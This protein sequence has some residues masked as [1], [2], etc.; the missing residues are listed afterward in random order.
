[1]A[2]YEPTNAR[3]PTTTDFAF[4]ISPKPRP[5]IM[6]D[7]SVFGCTFCGRN[8]FRSALA[9][10][11]HQEWT[12]CRY[13]KDQRQDI[14]DFSVSSKS[15]GNV[16]ADNN[17]F[18]PMDSP[19]S[20]P[21]RL[22][23]NFQDVQEVNQQD[24]DQVRANIGAL[25]DDVSLNEEDSSVESGRYDAF[26]RALGDDTP[27]SDE[28]SNDSHPE[29]LDSTENPTGA[30]KVGEMDAPVQ[31]GPIT[32]IR[33][34]YLEYCE[35]AKKNNAPFSDLE[36]TCIE[37][38]H[39]L[40][41]KDAPLNTYDM[42]MH[43]H[44]VQSKKIREH[45]TLRDCPYFIGRRTIFKKLVKRYNFQNKMPYQQTVR[46]PVS[47]T[48]VKITCHNAGASVQRL[49]TDPRI[50]AKD[51]LF[52]DGNPLGR[53]P[54]SLDYV[55]DL[56]TGLAFIETHAKLIEEANQQL[57]A[58]PLYCDG[59]AISHFHNMELI[60]VKMSLGVFTREARNKDHCWVPLGY[61][62][63]VHQ[64]GG[65]VRQ[66]SAEGNHIETQDD[67]Y[68][69]DDSSDE[70]ISVDGIGSKDD[71]D[72]HAMMAVVL[73]D[74]QDTL[75]ER[76]F[77]WD[78]DDGNGSTTKDIHYKTF[79]PFIRADTKEADLFAGKYGQRSST[80][81]ICR[82]CHIPLKQC[83]DHLAK[84]K[85]KTVKEIQKLIEK[86]D[87]EGLKNLSQTYLRNAFHEIRFSMGN[88]NGIHGSVPCELLHAFLLGTF[89][90]LR[91]T[92]FELIG[93][94]TEGAKMINALSKVYSRLFA[95]Q[96]D[97]TMPGTAFS[98]GINVGKLMAK[99]FRGVLL[100]MLAMARSTKGQKILK[101]HRHFKQQSDLDDWI[102]LIELMLEW[103]S[104]LNEPMMYV[105][106]VKRLEKKH[107][108]IMYIMRRV[109]RR[110][111]GMGL[112]LM[113]FH[114]I[115]HIWEDILQFGVPLEFDT[116]ANERMH[117][118]DKAAARRT[119]RASDTFNYQTALRLIEYELIDL[120]MEEIETGNVPWL[121]S[122]SPSESD[123]DSVAK[124]DK[125][126]TGETKITVSRNDNGDI[127]YQVHTKSKFVAKTRWNTELLAFLMELNDKVQG[128]IPTNS[129]PI[130]TKHERNGLIFRGHPNFRGKGA[131]RDWVWV[132]WKG[133]Y[134]RLPCHIW[135]FVVLVGMPSGRNAIKHGGIVL[136]DGTY[137]VVESAHLEE[138]EEELMRSDLMCPVLKEVEFDK[139]GMA[140]NRT[141]YLADTEAFV[142]PCCCIPDVG[143]PKNRYF[144][145]KPRN[146]WSSLFV[147]WLEDPHTL[148]EMDPLDAPESEEEE[149]VV[150]ED[151]DED[152]VMNDS[153]ESRHS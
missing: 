61:I 145:V 65:K 45:E 3:V 147:Q 115:L 21:R 20:P 135:C 107:R 27:N 56:N 125:I 98:R 102:L 93:K 77:M 16:E 19:P 52:W 75:Q 82:K 22:L 12:V 84:H 110:Q 44:L 117:K 33:D 97:R 109:A 122:L 47:G 37:L 96:S 49:L 67:M 126:R 48:M 151:Q 111:K 43:W 23:F 123:S 124:E 136:S 78:Q 99:D 15:Q 5:T 10:E 58:T 131:W 138:S 53:P 39:L 149:D 116:S 142:D 68:Y 89:K 108:F 81:Q 121:T 114:C 8:N 130:W 42:V 103:E 134:G 146:E 6:S 40:K 86:A 66:I 64:Q 13:L 41:R 60:T 91:D 141:F 7:P 94:S 26:A 34:Q 74:Y 129:V 29:D 32:W 106:H 153:D 70:H 59:T 38:L 88:D 120:A 62:E 132:D 140:C 105:K 150:E 55:R 127:M 85:F 63:K 95:R 76:G 112:K 80:K 24:M 11:Q 50:Q 35:W 71:Q 143:G 73:N 137:A 100:I 54:K 118:A 139:N 18:M 14:Q 72:F 31:D 83:D 87:F 104:Y 148:D 133:G 101:L 28:S 79:V 9:L 69:S 128:Y 17:D 36:K 1:M 30:L 2:P 25:W 57:M 152:S 90:Y 119:Q 144:V 4:L 92:F 51:Y 113:K 46:L